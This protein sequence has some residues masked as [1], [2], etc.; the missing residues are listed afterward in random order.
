MWF[1]DSAIKLHF[2]RES[3]ELYSIRLINS[4]SQKHKVVMVFGF[5]SYLLG[6]WKRVCV[7]GYLSFTLLTLFVCSISF[8]VV[9]VVPNLRL[10]WLSVS[11]GLQCDMANAV[12]V[13]LGVLS[14][15]CVHDRCF[16][17][18]VRFIKQVLF[19]CVNL[20][21]EN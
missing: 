5:D 9:Y 18:S 14:L 3:M 6:G 4:N 19:G 10:F 12:Y 8:F 15:K 1:C 2:G 7:C 16:W 13:R 17:Q 21:A 20:K 11:C